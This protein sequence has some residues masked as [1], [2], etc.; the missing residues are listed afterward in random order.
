MTE[1]PS[2]AAFRVSI[3]MPVYRDWQCAS[4]VCQALDEK[5]STLPQ[6]DARVLLVDDGS[7]HGVEGWTPFE[8]RALRQVKVLRLRRNLGHQRAICA[9]ICYIQQHFSCD[10]FLVMDA[11]GEDRVEDAIRLIDLAISHPETVFFAQRQRRFEGVL[12]QLGYSLYRATH[13]LL[14][15]VSVRVGNF[16]VVPCGALTR[17]TCMSE[18]WNHYAGAIFKSKLPFECVPMNR[19]RRAAGRSHMNFISLV[20]HGISGIATFSETV[21]TRIMISNFVGA[22]AL[23]VI[24][25][26]YVGRILCVTGT[27]PGWA[28]YISA[29]L[30]VLFIQVLWIAFSLVFLLMSNRTSMEF[31]PIRDYEVFVD[32]LDEAPGVA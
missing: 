8:R 13:W 14:T 20:A 25:A 24:L 28:A 6:V 10:A 21:A 26:C 5:L 22:I 31:V 23:T 9:G 17:L 27:I 3:L 2:G 11:D 29:L 4:V 19:G 18:L 30:L 32:R 7:T 16:S 1:S 12:F 15:G